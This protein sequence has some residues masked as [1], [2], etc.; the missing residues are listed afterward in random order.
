[1]KQL[2]NGVYGWDGLASQMVCRHTHTKKR[3]GLH[4]LKQ[5][6][7]KRTKREIVKLINNKREHPWCFFIGKQKVVSRVV[8]NATH[9]HTTHVVAVA[10]RDKILRRMFLST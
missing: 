2:N 8:K 1:M 5:K 9:I 6:S 4:F 10:G 3:A 7:N